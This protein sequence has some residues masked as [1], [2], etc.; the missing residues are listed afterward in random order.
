MLR[1]KLSRILQTLGW[2]CILWSV[3]AVVVDYAQGQDKCASTFIG[4]PFCTTVSWDR[5]V[6]SDIDHYT[7]YCTQPDGTQ[8][9]TDYGDRNST[10][11][12]CGAVPATMLGPMTVCT[13]TATDRSGNESEHSNEA[14]ICNQPAIEFRVLVDTSPPASGGIVSNLVVAS[15]WDTTS[16]VIVPDGFI[17]GAVV[18]TDQPFTIAWIH[19]DFD[20]L[21]GA[22]YIQTENAA[23][24]ASNN[25]FLTFTI[26]R[27]AQICVAMDHRIL[28][29][30]KVPTWLSTWDSGNHDLDGAATTVGNVHFFC[31]QWPSGIV[32]LG[33][34]EA[35]HSMYLVVIRG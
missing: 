31:K 24:N 15:P 23:Q 33:G 18:Y 13:V 1:L 21:R 25:P 16:F 26:N 29:S 6:D 9:V 27:A 7:F 5:G 3:F 4:K 22:T 10:S 20:E 11:I 12:P 34:N 19:N 32:Q 35:G 14:R 8:T 28:H 30:N 17:N 2:T